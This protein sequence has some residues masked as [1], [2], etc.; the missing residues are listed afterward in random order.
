MNLV[1]LRPKNRSRI[2]IQT[3]KLFYTYKRYARWFFDGNKYAK[4]QELDQLAYKITGHQTLLMRQL[5][6]VDMWYQ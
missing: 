5:K 3:G 6:D 2:R 4:Y 1:D